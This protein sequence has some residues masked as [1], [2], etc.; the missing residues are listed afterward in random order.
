MRYVH[1]SSKFKKDLKRAKRRGHD[2]SRLRKIISQLAFEQTLEPK[3]KDHALIG[4]YTGTR[5]CHLSPDWLLVYRYESSNKLILMRTG[6]HSD[7][8]K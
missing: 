6:T 2:V 8:F 4:N 7:L 1:Y 3:Y 5:E